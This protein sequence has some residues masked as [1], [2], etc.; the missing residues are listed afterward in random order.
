[1]EIYNIGCKYIISDNQEKYSAKKEI[2]IS[3][4][5]S[6]YI[7]KISRIMSNKKQYQNHIITFM[8]KVKI[9]IYPTNK[10]PNRTNG[11]QKQRGYVKLYYFTYPL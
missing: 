2:D 1:M 8:L 5:I 4:R 7:N 6:I 9:E 11:H 10:N 3:K